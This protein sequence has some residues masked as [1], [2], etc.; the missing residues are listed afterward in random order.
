VQDRST[1]LCNRLGELFNR[2]LQ[3]PFPEQ[4]DIKKRLILPVAMPV[5]QA[6]LAASPLSSSSNASG[7]GAKRPVLKECLRHPL[8]G[9]LIL[10][11]RDMFPLP[12][13]NKLLHHLRILFCDDAAPVFVF[14]T[15]KLR[16]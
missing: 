14:R 3:L 7:W 1:G 5:V 13:L 9:K 15:T 6:A 16:R 8:I 12:A 4:Q 10:K 11:R 2:I